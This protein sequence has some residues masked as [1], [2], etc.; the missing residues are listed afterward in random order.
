MISTSTVKKC[1]SWF[2]FTWLLMLLANQVTVAQII[3]RS[4]DLE[5]QKRDS[6]GVDTMVS[7]PMSGRSTYLNR[8]VDRWNTVIPKYKNIA[9]TATIYGEDIATIPVDDITNLFSGRLAGLYTVQSSG[10][11]GANYDNASFSLRG[12]TPILVIDGVVRSFTSFNPND[13]KS[14]T[15]MK[16]ALS[17]AMYGL[18]SSNG[19]IYI[20]TK[21]RSEEKPFELNFSAQYGI[22]NTLKTPNFI[23]GAGYASLY[24]EAQ[25]NTFP[26][27]TPAYSAAAIAA[28]QNGTNDPFLSPSTNWF[29]Q[30][31]K[32][33]T[34]QQRYNID[35]AGNGKTYRYYMS[36][37]NLS[38]T[39]NFLTSDVNSYNTNNDYS[40][41]NVRTNVQVDF[42]DAIQMNV[43]IFA[44]FENYNDSGTGASSVLGLA[45]Q[46]SPFAY[47]VYNADGSYGGNTTWKTNVVASN[48]SSGYNNY[49]NRS[50]NADV[51]LKYKFDKLVKGLWAKGFISVNN[52]YIEQVA[53]TKTF[54]V[55]YPNTATGGT[56]TYTQ[57]NTDGTVS[58]GK[59]VGT[60]SNQLK[61]TNASFTAG[62]DRVFGKNAI[63]I[64]GV[65]YSDNVMNS[66]TQLNAV[67]QNAGLTASYAY[68]KKYLAEA[69]LAYSGLN[70]YLPGKRWGL[71]PSAGLG[72]VI[73]NESWFK[74]KTV[75]FLKLKATAGQT[76]WADPTN[77]YVYLQTYGSGT[78]YNFGSAA[79]AV[80]GEQENTLANPDITW[81][82]A[83]KFEG[84]LEAA[85]LNNRLN[86]DVSYYYNNYY[87]QLQS[88]G[89]GYA[90]GLIGQSYTA[91]NIRKT[92]YN[93]I[94]TNIG[95]NNNVGKLAYFIKGNLSVS[96]SKLI[97][98]QEGNYPYPWLYQAGRAVGQTSG[99][100]AIGFYQAGDNFSTI[101]HLQGYTPQAGDVKYKDLNGDGI[102]NFLD[103]S[104]ITNNKP[105]IFYGLNLGASYRGFDIKVLFQGVTNRQVILSPS[106]MSAFSNSYGYVLDYTTDNRWTPQN[107]TDATLP[108]LTLGS[109]TNNQQVSSL[110]V[111]NASYL[112]LKNVELG[113]TL[114]K[115][116]LNHVKITNLRVF[117][118]AYNLVTWTKLEYFDPESLLSAFSNKRIIN[119]G[120]KIGL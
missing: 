43:N 102:I 13:I 17:T 71:L 33:Q 19:V 82:K 46:T 91:E 48:V 20:T 15:V 75:N 80:S 60:I 12:Q 69:A 28:Y 31:Y 21:D 90:T 112:R 76:A 99:Y 86:A 23:T 65:Y 4:A 64:T 108:R 24:N 107:T 87:D 39:G 101:P 29:Q 9:G 109:N 54:A 98:A 74:S 120:V 106:A 119:M 113:Y 45:Y 50:V 92:R 70:R 7:D 100:Q 84:G 61:Q 105:L 93:G 30:V 2:L 58:A 62:Y 77:Y 81:E 117:V 114:P 32:N 34:S 73:S 38:Q 89:N 56:T 40:R 47:P 96:Q 51:A 53:R 6:I 78:G 85:F 25:Q 37:E 22:L 18:R 97:D 26:G 72:W 52:Y 1:T 88:P 11:T 14:I 57:L 111:R 55:Y 94:E 118:N 41:Y 10:R 103:K 115:T 67:Y 42:S 27:V 49:N 5:R 59:G 16:D 104:I 110:W 35:A 63:N 83:W 95:F 44:G 3:N 8:G 68:S 79:T 116:L 66:I 36:I